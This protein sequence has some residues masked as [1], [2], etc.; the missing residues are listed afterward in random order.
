MC[1]VLKRN[2]IYNVADLLSYNIISLSKLNGL[3]YN[4]LQ[5]IIDVVSQYGYHF[6]DENS[7]I[8]KKSGWIK[9]KKHK[10]F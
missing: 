8:L 3:G 2:H 10:K 6:S 7:V 4:H 1:N 9:E 5:K